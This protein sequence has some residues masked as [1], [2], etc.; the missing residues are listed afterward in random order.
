[1]PPE[2]ELP[3]EE[4][5]LEEDEEEEE[6]LEELELLELPPE[7]EL[8]LDELEL[9]EDEEL[10]EDEEL[11]LDELDEL[12]LLELPPEEEELELLLEPQLLRLLPLT[13]MLTT[14]AP[15]KAP[16]PPKP[17]SKV[18]PLLTGLYLSQSGLVAVRLPEPS[19][20]MLPT[21][22]EPTLAEPASLKTM[23]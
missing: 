13:L 10:D 18:P 1:M 7:E 6:E 8:E 16:D 21:H 23:E 12:E 17:C 20:V 22:G 9:E 4:L 14:V 15:E 19:E 3:P 2:E 5:E 11:E